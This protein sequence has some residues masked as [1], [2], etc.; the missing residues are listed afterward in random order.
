MRYCGR[1]SYAATSPPQQSRMCG[2]YTRNYTWREV[3]DFLNLIFAV[4][5][6]P[7]SYNVA[8]T[9]MIP[10]TRTSEKG[11]RELAVARW[12]LV[13]SWSKEPASGPPLFNARAADRWSPHTERVSMGWLLPLRNESAA[14]RRR[15]T[16]SSRWS[17]GS[18]FGRGVRTAPDRS[19]L[20]QS[21]T[22][23][24]A[25]RRSPAIDVVDLGH[26]SEPR[27]G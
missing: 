4:P 15:A 2:R 12:G 26:S 3:R 11:A 14:P 13:P 21:H 22:R 19:P 24:T 17:P 8:P 25:P 7:P 27:P 23:L 10:I 5:E 18:A 16:S 20:R 1:R 6:M 9:Q